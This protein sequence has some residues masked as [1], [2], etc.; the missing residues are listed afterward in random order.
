MCSLGASCLQT[1]R[2]NV[3]TNL[4]TVEC[5]QSW[6]EIFVVENGCQDFRPETLLVE[7]K[8]TFE[9]EIRLFTS[10]HLIVQTEEILDYTMTETRKEHRSI[11]R[12][13]CEQTV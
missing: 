13:S 12:A 10:D 2:C 6:S 8:H 9:E 4:L 7:T 3:T 5:I 1:N 11:A